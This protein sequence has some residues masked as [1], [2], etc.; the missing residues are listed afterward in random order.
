MC[1]YCNFDVYTHYLINGDFSLEA[2]H[3]TQAQL[4]ETPENITTTNIA[5]T[6]INILNNAFIAS[7]S[8][9]N[10]TENT[11][12]V[13]DTLEKEEQSFSL[14]NDAISDNNFIPPTNAQPQI[15]IN[16]VR[17][18]DSSVGRELTFTIGLDISSSETVTVDYATTDN[19]A[20]KAEDYQAVNGTVTFAPGE[21]SKTIAVKTTGTSYLDADESFYVN[22]SNASNATIEDSQGEGTILPAYAGIRGWS[23]S[24]DTITF[25]FFDEDVFGQG[26]YDGSQSESNARE[27]SEVV[28][29]SY[30][31]IFANLNTFVDRDFIEVAESESGVGDIRILIS[32]APD[33]A[34][35][36]EHIHLAGWAAA[37][38]MGNNGWES[39][40]GVYGYS[41]L[42]HELGHALGM[43][44]A[45]GT[46]SSVFAPEDNSANT[47]M[48]YNFPGNSPAT[49]MAYDIKSLQERYGA[50]KYRLEDT[51]YKFVTVDNY[52]VD[53]ELSINDDSRIKQTVWDSGG[54]DTFDFSGLE[55]NNSGYRF[56]LN[57]TKFQTT[58]DGD[59]GSSYT[60]DNT[61]YYVPTYGTS[62]AIDVD[63]ENLVNSSSDDIIIANPVA[64]TFSGY[65]I[66]LTTGNDLLIAADNLDTLDLSGFSLSEVKQTQIDNDLEIELSLADSI[67]I[68]DY[69]SAAEDNRINILWNNGKVDIPLPVISVDD[70][71]IKERDTD[72]TAKVTINLNKPGTES[73]TVDYATADNTA[74]ANDDY[75]SINDTVTFNPGETSKTI[76]IPVIGDTV[77]ETNESF[78]LNLD[79]A[80]N[81]VVEDSQAEITIGDNDD[82]LSSISVSDAG[83]LSSIPVRDDNGNIK[84]TTGLLFE[85][86][87]D[88]PSSRTVWVDYATQDNTAVVGEDYSQENNTLTFQ[89]GE[90]AK[91]IFVGVTVDDLVEADENLYFNLSNPINATI[92]DNQA[93]GTIEEMR[94]LSVSDAEITA[95]STKALFTVALDKP[96]V[97]GVFV[98]Y[99][100][101]DATARNYTDNGRLFIKAGETSATVAVPLINNTEADKTFF[102]NLSDPKYALIED[103]QGRTI[104]TNDDAITTENTEYNSKHIG[105]VGTISNLDRVNRT[106]ELDHTYTNPVVFAMPLSHNGDD[107]AIA[108]ITDIQSDS[109]SVYV[110]E[111]EYEDG[112]HTRESFSYMVLEAGTWELE[113]GTTL[114]VGT[115][116]TNKV[117]TS[118]WEQLN[119]EN[120]FDSSPAILS[121]VQTDNGGEFIRTR[122][123]GAS[124]DGFRLTMEEEEALQHSGHATETVGWL[125][126]ESGSGSWSGLDY[127]AGSTGTEIDHTWDTVT[128]GQT[129]DEA[130]NLLA[131]LSSYNGSDSAGLRYKNLGSSS[132]RLMVEEDRSLDSEI[133]HVNESVDFLA[134]AGS[135]DLTA[136]VY[137][138]DSFI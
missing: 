97:Q 102:L 136:S 125:A 90:T 65:E 49:F 55:I 120:D 27:V 79:N 57:Q 116:D 53:G 32:D 105:E 115:I 10:S 16:D 21:T 30:R 74:L 133:G 87:L 131:S 100:T 129:F 130:P 128:F 59:R 106:I 112:S 119:F 103:S 52:L 104:I 46:D 15:S 48:S 64:N 107:P 99:S 138:T 20:V 135:G 134:I 80:V 42:I 33:Y 11:V 70:I 66:G 95:E 50:A 23:R 7:Q 73:I 126:I 69:Y 89:P 28:K 123:K 8:E 118:G 60:I 83:V 51:V 122:Q 4:N 110:Q 68:Q 58:Q 29:E 38:D 3:A 114:E 44:H 86:T 67:T 26:G 34:Y 39:D 18:I 5:N 84:N 31:Q 124:V 111:A 35:A 40:P 47:V 109:F 2:A 25:S 113:N 12:K 43:P 24:Q 22:L 121:Q 101:A 117:S 6:S 93:I 88:A 71:T 45:F 13:T 77:D 91:Q 56:D 98:D 85:V 75:Q 36:G 41:A 108:R 81:A 127:Q 9:D 61:I 37:S 78:Y 17:L 63:I 19:T 96:S 137:N 62:I 76:K 82:P 72:S 94:S 132:V 1:R 14:L 92:A 54:I